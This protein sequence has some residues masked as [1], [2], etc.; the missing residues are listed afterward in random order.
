MKHALHVPTVGEFADPRVLADLAASADERGWDGF[1][2]WDHLLRPETEPPEVADTLTALAAV[3]SVTTRIRLGPMVAPP[4][5]YGPQRLARASVTLDQ[6]SAGRLTLGLGL[7]HDRWG[8][9]RRF[10]EPTDP[11]ERGELLDEG[12]ELLV[13]LWSGEE[14]RHRG[15]H[16]V[17]D[18]VRFLPVPV[19]RP[20]IP[21]WFAARGNARRPV[22]RAARY[23]GLFPVDVDPDQL[24]RMLDQVGA[25]RGS[26][27]GFDVAVSIPPGGDPAPYAARGA[28]WVFRGVQ[29]H[30][31]V[32][33]VQT[34]VEA[35]PEA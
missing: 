31:S 12:I 9:L 10:G 13:A 6:L 2:L 7:G 5:R 8:E 35:G 3:A 14:V 22:R 20:R 29:P 1:F 25:E 33:D 21:L 27:E 30:D 11:R 4:A 23:E 16:Y 24:A 26:M 17:A 19:Q 32:K 34:W 18:P 15:R 28:T